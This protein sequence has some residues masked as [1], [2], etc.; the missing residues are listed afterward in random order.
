MGHVAP[1]VGIVG[2]GSIGSRHAREL[3]ALGAVVIALRRR[4]DAPREPA[5][6]FAFV[7]EVY[8]PEQFWQRDLDAVIVANPSAQHA[9]T[10]R[11]ALERTS[12]PVMVEKPV[13]A[14]IAQAERIPKELRDRVRVGYCL[15]FHPVV[16]AVDETLKA[17]AI[18]RVIAGRLRFGSMLTDWR[19]GSDY[20]RGYAARPELGGGALRTLSH[21]LDLVQHWL[22][23]VAG[24]AGGVGKV[25]ALELGE[26]EDLAQLSL[27]TSSGA[28]VAVEIDFVTPGYDRGG[29]LVGTA[30]RLDYS[31]DRSGSTLTVLSAA[32]D[33]RVCLGGANHMYSEQA[34]DLLRLAARGTSRACT[35]S[36]AV[37]VLAIVEAAEHDRF[38]EVR[39]VSCPRSV[40]C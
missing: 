19:P 22:G 20:R 37:H 21:E 15:R 33:H 10:A 36:E 12:G 7:E 11:A 26:V 17:G 32:G 39:P 31:L 35:F 8:E 18:G 4:T 38:T 6:E 1:T 28:M 24:V 30:G 5:V 16:R 40:Q 2:L 23:P 14:T 3:D 34:R 29:Q 25:S 13:A 27:R 9:A